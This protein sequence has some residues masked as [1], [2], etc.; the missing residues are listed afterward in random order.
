[1]SMG[2]VVIAAGR[3]AHVARTLT[4]L[5]LQL[6]RADRTILVDLGSDPP[7]RLL[8]DDIDRRVEVVELSSD[9]PGGLPLAAGRNAGAVAAATDAL[10]FLDADCIAEPTLV[11]R[12]ADVLADH[13]DAI[14]CG[15]V[16]YLRQ[17]WAH[18]LE[19]DMAGL[20]ERS[21]APAARPVPPDGTVWMDDRHELFWSLSFGVSAEAWLRTAG[22]DAGFVGY[23]SEDTDFA[24]RARTLGLRLAWFAGG[25]AFHQWHEPSRFDPA[26]VPE[27]VS[28]A[29]RF[30]RRWGCWPMAGWLAELAGLGI[31]RF[32]PSSD[33]LELADAPCRS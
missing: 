32:D 9:Q 6:Q 12:Y 16:R 1:M 5:T 11:S 31:I 17:G 7:L 30:R 3:H 19:P 28:N 10:V 23:G 33:V 24:L 27:L 18:P 29:R 8:A 21:E 14:A 4:A 15:P 13:T 2:V 20:F 26:R 22:F 25:T